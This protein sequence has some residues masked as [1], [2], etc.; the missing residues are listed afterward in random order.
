MV[1]RGEWNDAPL[2]R[3]GKGLMIRNKI[4]QDILKK[5]GAQTPREAFAVLN[6]CSSE[7]I[8]CEYFGFYGLEEHVDKH[9]F[10]C[11][12]WDTQ[13]SSLYK[14]NGGCDWRSTR[15]WEQKLPEQE[16][17]TCP[18][19]PPAGSNNR[20]VDL[21]TPPGCGR[22]KCMNALHAWRSECDGAP[23]PGTPAMELDLT[24]LGRC[25][26]RHCH[27]CDG[28]HTNTQDH[29]SYVAFAC[30]GMPEPSGASALP[31]PEPEPEPEPAV[32][33]MC[34][35]ST[36]APP[37]QQSG[38]VPRTPNPVDELS[39][40]FGTMRPR[41]GSGA[42]LDSSEIDTLANTLNITDFFLWQMVTIVNFNIDTGSHNYYIHGPALGTE[43]LEDNHLWRVIS[44]DSDW[45]F[46][47]VC[48]TTALSWRLC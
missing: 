19:P 22:S 11:M 20:N 12:G 24:A 4:T 35:Q 37:T 36:N 45:G 32:P 23:Y 41:G 13:S 43:P 48:H 31:E 3:G 27:C 15:G 21:P 5:A 40:L 8:D 18:P 6:I 2:T 10:E 38:C 44:I 42:S 29:C 17:S 28:S 30:C 46:G 9:W 33:C 47:Y 7:G 14:A 16:Y 25:D 34:S 26:G 1:L 39:Q